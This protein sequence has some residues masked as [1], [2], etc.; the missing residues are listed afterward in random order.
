MNARLPIE[1]ITQ[2][3]ERAKAEGIPRSE[4]IRRL[5]QIGLQSAANAQ[6]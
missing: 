1:M 2:L 6:D 3:D 4:L 5:I